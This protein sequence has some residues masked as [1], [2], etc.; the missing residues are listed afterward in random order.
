MLSKKKQHHL[1][2]NFDLSKDNIDALDF[3]KKDRNE[4]D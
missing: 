4:W 2:K 3:Q 1:K